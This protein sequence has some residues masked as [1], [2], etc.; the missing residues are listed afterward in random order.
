MARVPAHPHDF[1]PLPD[2]ALHVLLALA[3]EDLHGWAI[4]KRI[5][6]LAP[7][8]RRPSSGSLYLSMVRL[9]ERGLIAEVEGPDGGDDPRRR[10]YTLTRLGRRVLDAETIRLSHLVNHAKRFG[11]GVRARGR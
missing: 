9:E 8:R 6:A 7:N 10:Y 3:E 5:G 11:L 2:L 1:L 4:I